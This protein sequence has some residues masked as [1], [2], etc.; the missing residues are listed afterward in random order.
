MKVSP[1]AHMQQLLSGQGHVV[2]VVLKAGPSR[3]DVELEEEEDDHVHHPEA[4]SIKKEKEWPNMIAEDVV[5]ER[6]CLG[7]T[8]VSRQNW[9]CIIKIIVNV[10]NK[11]RI[12]ATQ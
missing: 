5:S 4:T 8:R 11:I 10:L 2:E 9:T 12:Y 7:L 1:P 3:K 6:H